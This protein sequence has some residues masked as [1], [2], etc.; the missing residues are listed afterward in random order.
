MNKK[1]TKSQNN[2]VLTGTLAGIAEYFG[3]DPT[4]ARVI[5]VFAS[6]F[7]IGAPILLYILLAILI[8]NAKTARAT[9]NTAITNQVKANQ[10]KQKQ[11]LMIFGEISK[12]KLQKTIQ[13]T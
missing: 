1:M 12:N 2:R 10:N 11:P 13:I 8:P 7:L 3:V 6:V 5:Y 4:L 9:T